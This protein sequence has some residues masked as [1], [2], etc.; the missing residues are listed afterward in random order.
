MKNKK[1]FIIFNVTSKGEVKSAM[2]VTSFV[3]DITSKSLYLLTSK[4]KGIVW[5]N[6]LISALFFLTDMLK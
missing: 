4:C 1:S 5:K 3:V 6:L 2:I